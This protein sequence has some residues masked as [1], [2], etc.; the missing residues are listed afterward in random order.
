MIDFK[1]IRHK[2]SGSYKGQGG[3]FLANWGIF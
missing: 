2:D 3:N 1:M